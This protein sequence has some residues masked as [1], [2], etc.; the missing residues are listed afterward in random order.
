MRLKPLI[1]CLFASLLLSG[2]AGTKLK[3]YDWTDLPKEQ[4]AIPPF[5]HYLAQYKIALDPGHDRRADHG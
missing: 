1:G 3:L 2:C 4:Y 5:A